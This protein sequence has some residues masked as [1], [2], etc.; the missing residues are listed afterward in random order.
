LGEG[1]LVQNNN[2][3]I[4]WFR[5]SAEQGYSKGQIHL[6]LCLYEGKGTEKDLKESIFW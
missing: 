6:A 2:E 4:K 1:K 5:K 3:A